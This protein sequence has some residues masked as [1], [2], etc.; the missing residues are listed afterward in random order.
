[1]GENEMKVLADALWGY[2]RDKYFIPYLSDSVCYFQATVTTA[3]SGGVIGVQRPFDNVMTIPYAWSAESLTVGDQCTVLMFG[4]MNNCIAIGDGTLSKPGNV[5]NPYASNP[6]MDG[7]AS[8]GSS[9]DYSRG[10]HIHPTDTSRAPTSHASSATT[11]GKGDGTNYGHLKLSDSTST[12]SGV[13]GGIAATPTAVKAAY[14]LANGKQDPL[15]F[16]NAP[17]SGSL[18]PVTSDGI[19]TAISNATKRY[20]QTFRVQDWTT[21]INPSRSVIEI[22]ASTHG[23]GTDPNVKVYILNGSDY[24]EYHGYPSKGWKVSIDADGDITLTTSVGGSFPGKIK[25]SQ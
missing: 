8:P 25:V 2:F 16:D 17:T 1:M 9:N 5:P 7:T 18:N 23:C 24:E 20:S 3:P 6:Q 4:D 12:T 22:P 19:Y 13:S 15:T 10:D 11:Y 21:Y 14:D